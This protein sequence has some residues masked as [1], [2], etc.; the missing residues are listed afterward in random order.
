MSVTHGGKARRFDWKLE[1]DL[2]VIENEDHKRHSFSVQE[3]TDVLAWLYQRFGSSWIPLANNVQK[4]YEGT[5]IAGLGSAIYERKPGDTYH[6][7]G[8]SY[9]GVVLEE[10]GILQWN[11]EMKGIAWRMVSPGKLNEESVRDALQKSQGVYTQETK[12]FT[13]PTPQHDPSYDIGAHTHNFALW[14]AARAAQ[15]NFTTVENFRNAAHA[16]DLRKE[17]AGIDQP[18]LD[19]N[20]FD[21]WHRGICGRLMKS[22][23]DENVQNVT[24]GRMAKFV[25]IYLKVVAVIGSDP[26]GPLSQVAHP[27]IDRILL[28]N[29]AKNNSSLGDLASVN[30]T[31]LSEEEYFTVVN[32]LRTVVDKKDPFWKLERFWTPVND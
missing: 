15:R 25:A 22:L 27:P 26:E 20:Q 1:R 24:Y 32:A 16:C 12:V 18:D 30:W 21:K 5:E 28:Q 23:V 4:M 3:I 2:V 6:A 13:P 19:S 11:N 31:D 9:L 17:V 8:A 10:A 14:A 7:Q 29:V